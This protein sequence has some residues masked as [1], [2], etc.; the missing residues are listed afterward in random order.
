MANKKADANK[1]RQEA[2]GYNLAARP[3]Q[4]WDAEAKVWVHVDLR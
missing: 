2:K 1:K 3:V 4:M